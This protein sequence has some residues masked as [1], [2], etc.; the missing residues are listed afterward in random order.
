LHVGDEV[1]GAAFYY[2][3]VVATEAMVDG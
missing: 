1:V 2:V 3:G